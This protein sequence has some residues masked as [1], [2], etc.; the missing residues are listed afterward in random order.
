MT[1]KK[2]YDIII[3]KK[4]FCKVLFKV[5]KLVLVL[6]TF[7]LITEPGMEASPAMALSFETLAIFTL[8]LEHIPYI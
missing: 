7:K 8:L 6:A 3:T 4:L 1:S 5:K 2:A